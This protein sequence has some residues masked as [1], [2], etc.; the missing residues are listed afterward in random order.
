MKSGSKRGHRGVMS[1]K[2]L[3]SSKGEDNESLKIMEK[4]EKKIVRFMNMYKI[5]KKKQEDMRNVNH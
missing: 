5:E 2:G 3:S 1:L 4:Q